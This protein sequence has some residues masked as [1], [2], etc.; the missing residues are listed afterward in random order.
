MLH[1]NIT[2]PFNHT[3][4]SWE[5]AS[6]A[7][8]AALTLAPT[9]IGRVAIQAAPADVLVLLDDVAP[10]WASLTLAVSAD[11]A[12][13][14]AGGYFVAADLE[15][16][17]QELAAVV[18][19]HST[20]VTQCIAIALGN[21]TTPAVVGT[22]IVRFT[23]PY[24]FT[25]SEVVLSASIAQASG[26]ILTVDVNQGGTSILS[27]KLTI[28]NTETSSVTA[29]TPAVISTAALI[30]GSVISVDIDQIGTTAAGLKLYLV[31]KVTV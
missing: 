16:V 25:L 1:R 13:V 19:E 30:K 10:T 31:G 5:V 29:A 26:S 17:L 4:H 9:D 6:P 15:D 14:D 2:H 23:V 20:Q 3:I 24:N 18:L 12:I 21:E 28:D 27:T 8:L 7:A 22:N 11:I